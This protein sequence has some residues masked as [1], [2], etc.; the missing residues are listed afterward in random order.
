MAELL[1]SKYG[2]SRRVVNVVKE[3]SID[4]INRGDR[5]YESVLIALHEKEKGYGS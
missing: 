1:N 3:L 4:N 5:D 2:Q